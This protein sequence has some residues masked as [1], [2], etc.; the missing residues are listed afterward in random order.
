MTRRLLLSLEYLLPF[1]AV[2]L[3]LWAA[4]GWVL[5]QAHDS[6]VHAAYAVGNNLARSLAQYEDSSV[7]A[8]D[9]SL[10]LLRD[11]WL[12]DRA[13]FG[14][15]LARHEENLQK[16][17]VIQLAVVD[18]KGDLLY[19]KMP[20]SGAPNFADRDYFRLQRAA[21]RD[22]LYV[23]SPV[24][25]RVTQQWAIQFSRP[26]LAGD[27]RFAG[28]IVMALPPPALEDVYKDIDL[29]PQGVITLA[30]NDGEILARTGPIGDARRVSLADTIALRPG[31]G[32]SG[33]FRALGRVDGVERFFSYRKLQSYPLTVIVGQEADAVLAPYYQQRSLLVTGGVLATLLLMA[34]G[35]VLASRARDR[36]RFLAERERLALDLHDGCIQSIYAIGLGLENCRRFLDKDPARAAHLLAEAGAGLNLVIQ[37]LRSFI[38]GIPRAPQTQ[39]QFVQEIRRAMPAAGAGG[40]A[41]SFDIDREAVRALT[42]EQAMHVQRIAQEAVSNVM[43]H[44]AARN[45]RLTLALRERRV[46]LDVTDD[47]GG[48]PSDAQAHIGLGLHNIQA[49]ARKLG[50]HA[51]VTSTPER[52]THIQV[53]FP[54]AR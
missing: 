29:G 44:A 23:S 3:I 34:L 21:G 19:S 22:Q 12:R 13:S 53:E 26:I 40:P 52:G 30:R 42:P 46:S 5:K 32:Q 51:R 39:E 37:D 6:A 54:Q 45:A 24:Y 20:V 41:F 4:I 18:D 15:A 27:G 2:A 47:G 28:L 9:L 50:G 48:I 43:R 1:A 11:Q 10:R 33:D 8:I 49:R 36:Q 38:S 16:E 31:A 35:A 7:R 25:G 17:R 14:V